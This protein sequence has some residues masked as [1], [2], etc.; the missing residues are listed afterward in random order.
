MAQ[1]DNQ[2]IASWLSH[3][4]V[5]PEM[6]SPGIPA[7]WF[8][9]YRSTEGE[10]WNIT[11]YSALI[12][13]D[14][15][16]EC[17]Q[18]DGGWDTHI[19]DGAPDVWTYYSRGE[20]ETQEYHAFG[21]AKGIEPLV[22]YR[23]FHGMR[24]SF[25]EVSPEF[26]LFHN[27]YHEPKRGRYLHFDDNG[28]ESEAVRYGYGFVEIRTDLLKRFCDTK[29]MALAVYVDS[30][31]RSTASLEE[32][33]LDEK[34]ENLKGDF[35]SV[36]LIVAPE[37]HGFLRPGIKTVGAIHASKKY[38]LPGPMPGEGDSPDETYQEFVIGEDET[39]KPIR[40][41][42]DPDQLAN[43]F[44]KNPDAPHYLT[45]V[46]FRPEVL[47]KYHAEPDKYSVEDGYLRCGGLWGIRM[48]NDD[49]D[50]V[51]LFLGDLGR[52]LSEDERH[53]WLS[54][55]I[56]PQGRTMSETTYRRS[57]RAMPTNPTRA[58]HAFKLAYDQFRKRFQEAR[59]WDFFLPL[60]A[61][62]EHFLTALRILAKDN[63]SE[64]DSQLIALT[65]ILIDS[66]NEK[67]IAKGLTTLETNSK[68][69]TKLE[70]FLAENGFTGY[71]DHIKFLRVLQDLRSKSSAHRKGSSYD[72]LVEELE[73]ADEGQKAVFE[74][75]LRE[76]EGL[77]GYLSEG[78]LP[79][80]ESEADDESEIKGKED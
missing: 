18:D 65:K 24:E 30:F 16:A 13:P 56:P 3:E 21:N 34:R 10:G 41:T 73:L 59:G 29:Q 78:L 79:A 72:K 23:D 52:D 14:K 75:L 4:D 66:L 51:M 15:V 2:K 58:D 48:D 36:S 25:F 76:A 42:C 12:P 7:P 53:Y 1:D 57:F 64:F 17:I 39:G 38:V 44:G 50:H 11:W 27:L 47:A 80:K 31:R 8:S 40:Y 62:D 49:P 20:E 22:I 61:D 67:Q 70:C 60:H 63:Q 55:N 5:V 43:Y 77:I 9:A 6:T 46:F 28:N 33:G 69:I 45:S 26:R 32:L 68:G 35:Y 71:E 54:Y 37:Q 74:K 19:G